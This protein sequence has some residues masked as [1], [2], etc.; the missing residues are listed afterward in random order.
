MGSKEG[1]DAL[2]KD[3]YE[4]VKAKRMLTR[5]KWATGIT[6]GMGILHGDLAHLASAGMS[7]LP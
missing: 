3:A 7:L 6:L 4:A 1:A 2:M 5:A